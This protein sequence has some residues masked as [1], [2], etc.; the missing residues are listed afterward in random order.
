[1][2][3]NQ[4][5]RDYYSYD[6]CYDCDFIY[7]MEKKLRSGFLDDIFVVRIFF[8]G[9]KY[10]QS[11]EKK[12]KKPLALINCRL[13]RKLFFHCIISTLVKSWVCSLYTEA[14]LSR[15]AELLLRPSAQ[16]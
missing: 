9:I 15:Q 12:K 6:Y 4:S 1:M 16:I 10:S 5:H 8:R 7:F 3:Q 11:F 13:S 14:N 2:D